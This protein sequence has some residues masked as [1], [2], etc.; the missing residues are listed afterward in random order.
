MAVE[1]KLGKNFIYYLVVPSQG[2]RILK[3][4]THNVLKSELSSGYPKLE[5]LTREA[6]EVFDGVYRR[7]PS[8]G[9][10]APGV[11][12]LMGDHTDYNQGFA[13]PIVSHVVMALFYFSFA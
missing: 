8:H 13:L 12:N 7:M 1:D 6:V 9:S 3:L 11:I 4:N 5:E 10:F 2:A